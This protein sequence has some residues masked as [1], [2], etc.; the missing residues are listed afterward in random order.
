MATRHRRS[1]SAARSDDADA[2]IPEP[3]QGKPARTDDDLAEA[4][5]EGFVASATAGENVEDEALEAF[6][7]EEIGGP[8]IESGAER[9]FAQGIDEANPE[10]A[11][12]EPLPRAV[13]GLVQDATEEREME[14]WEAGEQIERD[15][16]DP[17]DPDDHDEVKGDDASAQAQAGRSASGTEGDDD[18]RR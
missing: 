2:F 5:A 9:E 1:R 3:E 15:D 7:P 4:L 18:R 12:R 17:D 13:A 10:G 14:A 11:D 6:V 8:F 16:H